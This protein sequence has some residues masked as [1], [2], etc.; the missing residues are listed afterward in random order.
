VIIA[1]AVFSVELARRAGPERASSEGET[2]R[3]VG[4][5]V[6]IDALRHSDLLLVHYVDPEAFAR[7][8]E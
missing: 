2:S 1:A 6:I 4:R 5:D 3:R 8:C 7:K